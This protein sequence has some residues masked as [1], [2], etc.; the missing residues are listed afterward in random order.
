MRN[1]G[2]SEGS[3]C[4]GLSR[5]GKA[6]GVGFEPTEAFTS[7]VFKTGAINHSTTPPGTT[8]G[9]GHSFMTSLNQYVSYARWLRQVGMVGLE[10]SDPVV[11]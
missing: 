2:V 7:P 11:A 5:L 1:S 6:E 3:G 8:L 4:L 9:L 10:S